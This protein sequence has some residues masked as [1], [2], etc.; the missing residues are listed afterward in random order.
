MMT[1]AINEI[2]AINLSA[3]DWDITNQLL[4]SPPEP[5]E[6][7]KKLLSMKNKEIGCEEMDNR[8]AK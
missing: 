1:V 7:L 4:L 2:Y 3:K 8:K 5:N 6:N